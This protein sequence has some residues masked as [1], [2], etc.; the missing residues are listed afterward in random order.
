[1]EKIIING[2]KLMNW[3]SFHNYFSKVFG[4]PDFYGRNMNAWIDC[5]GDIDHPEHGMTKNISIK[6]GESI[7]FVI[8][9]AR[10]LE[11]RK[12]EIYDSLIEWSSFINQRRI[13]DGKQPLIFLSFK[14]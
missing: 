12:K 8:Q 3:K 10:E 14:K 9:H 13:E 11:K 5:M 4:F 2:K 6:K 7:E 1:V